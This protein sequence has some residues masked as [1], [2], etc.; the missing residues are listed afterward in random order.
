MPLAAYPDLG[1]FVRAAR[2]LPIVA[3]A[4]FAG[5]VVGGFVIFA[6]N[7]TLAPQ[8]PDPGTNLDPTGRATA[9]SVPAKPVPIVGAPT[10]NPAVTQPPAAAPPLQAPTPAPATSVATTAQ[11]A[12]ATTAQTAPQDAPRPTRWPNALMRGRKVIT[13]LPPAVTPAAGDEEEKSAQTEHKSSGASASADEDHATARR[14]AHAAKKRDRQFSSAA[15]RQESDRTYSRVYDYEGTADS[16]ANGRGVESPYFGSQHRRV[17]IRGQRPRWAQPAEV[18]PPWSG[19][20]WGGG[21]YRD[22]Q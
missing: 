15:A 18:A 2:I 7:G 22:G 14:H 12:V 21:Y 6:I 11:T 17:I 5:G 16:D 9:V 4:A 3:I 20:F 10:P 19:Q 8:R 1:L 13:P